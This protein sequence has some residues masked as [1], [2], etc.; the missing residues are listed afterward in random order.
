M[1]ITRAFAFA[2]AAL[3]ATALAHAHGNE[4][5]GAVDESKAGHSHAASEIHGGKVVMTPRYHFEVAFTADAVRVYLYDG[6][7]KPLSIKGASGQAKVTIRRGKT[8][9]LPLRYVGPARPGDMDA[10]EGSFAFAG[11]ARGAAK[12]T[13]ELKGLPD[14]A[15]RDTVFRATF[16]DPSKPATAGS[17]APS[18]A[19]EHGHGH[20]GSHH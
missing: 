8:T 5:H 4:Q 18:P 3:Y 13:F 16:E 12:L 7:Q 10:L 17:P 1:N 9:A 2:I 19:H 20:G 15:E 6:K 14:P 11:V